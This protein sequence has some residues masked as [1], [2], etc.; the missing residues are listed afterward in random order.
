MYEDVVEQILASP[1][2]ALDTE[3]TGDNKLIPFEAIIEGAAPRQFHNQV[4]FLDPQRIQIAMNTAAYWA[5]G[6]EDFG[7]RRLGGRLQSRLPGQGPNN[8]FLND[9][10]EIAIEFDNMADF[11][12]TRPQTQYRLREIN[13]EAVE[14]YMPRPI[15]GRVT[16]IRARYLRLGHAFLGEIDPERGWGSLARGGV[17]I[18]Y[19]DGT[20]AGVLKPPH[21]A[22]LAAELQKALREAAGQNP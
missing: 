9:E 14:A 7:G 21:A 15:N 17:T 13:N 1:I 20:H 8:E 19:V 22:Q 3:T 5:R 16:L 6:Y 10:A 2:V 18:R 11:N 12:A 4:S